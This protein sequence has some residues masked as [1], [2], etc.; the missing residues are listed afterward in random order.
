MQPQ[1]EPHSIGIGHAGLPP[2][3]SRLSP[4]PQRSRPQTGAKRCQRVELLG[5]EFQ[6]APRATTRRGTIT[7]GGPKR[8]HPCHFF[9]GE[10]VVSTKVGTCVAAPAGAGGR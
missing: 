3:G 6:E 7:R 5:V 8:D 10:R 4:P 9:L 2:A 1:E